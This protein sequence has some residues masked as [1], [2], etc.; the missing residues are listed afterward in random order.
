MGVSFF[1]MVSAPTTPTGGTAS[2]T[3]RRRGEKTRDK[4]LVA[5]AKVFAR[6]GYHAARVDDIVT[7]AAISHGTFYL[8]FASKDALFESLIGAISDE[9][10]SLVGQLPATIDGSPASRAEFEEW[11]RSVAD[12]TARIGPFMHVWVSTD[13]GT[14]TTTETTTDTRS[15]PPRAAVMTAVVEG[16][17]AAVVASVPPPAGTADALDVAIA[18]TSIWAMFERLCQ[19]AATKQLTASASE[20]VEVTSTIFFDTLRLSD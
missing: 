20:L 4:L 6:R 7:A 17:S 12:L 2:S 18:V 5:G 16:L 1:F 11:L 8:Y 15:L 19:Y 13:S 3:R 9:F 10:M 14:V